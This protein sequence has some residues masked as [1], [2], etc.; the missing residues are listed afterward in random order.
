MNMLGSNTASQMIDFIDH[1]KTIIELTKSECANIEVRSNPQGSQSFDLPQNLK[2]Q[3]GPNRARKDS[4]S[5]LL[6]GNWFAK[7]YYDMYEAQAKPKPVNDFI[8]RII[9]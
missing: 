3:T 1:Q 9:K 8:P 2:R 4:Y 5:A 7:I 6:L